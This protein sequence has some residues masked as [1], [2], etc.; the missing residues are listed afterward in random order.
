MP[1]FLII[2]VIA[3]LGAS[4]GN[5]AKKKQRTIRSAQTEQ[6]ATQKKIKETTKKLNDNSAQTEKELNKLNLLRGEITQKER[7]I[8][9]TRSQID[10]LSN[11][12]SKA[13]DQLDDLNNRL[14][15]LKNAYKTALRRLQ[16]TQYATNELAYIFG[17]E[18]FT[19]AYSRI[20]YTQ[21]FANWRRRKSKE[22][23]ETLAKIEQKK[24]Q[25][26]TLHSERATSLSA[27]SSDQ[28]ILKAKQDETDKTVAKLQ[29]DGVNLQRAL[30]K[31]KKRLKSIDNEISKMIEVERRER[32]Q[33]KK[34]QQDQKKGGTTKQK[35]SKTTPAKSKGG[36]TATKPKTKIDNSDPDA[37]MTSKFAAGKGSMLFPVAS[38]YRIVAKYGSSNGQ[39]YNTGIEIVLDG[40][41]NVRS[42]FEGTV[43]RI[44]Q[45]HDGNYSIMVRHGAYITVYYNI[46]SLSVKAKEKVTAGQTLGRAAT[47]A[48]YGKPMLHFEVRKGSETLNPLSWVR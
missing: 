30:D 37:A 1:R 8:L 35:D 31:E 4:G 45:N 10:T 14:E 26:A 23:K 11:S 32:E 42:I 27:L 46:G 43:S 29:R 25:L 12:I 9:E 39:P 33:Q 7:Q 36:T 20:R 18:S 40:S 48:R 13:Q 47:D 15:Q 19:K 3:L 22:I 17:S 34:K 41:A 28:A 44:F 2:L 21:E 24:A 38:P 6:Q 5:A 16:G